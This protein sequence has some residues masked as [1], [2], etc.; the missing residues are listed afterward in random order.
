MFALFIDIQAV[1]KGGPL[2]NDLL[3]FSDK[4]CL[5]NFVFDK[6]MY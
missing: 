3:D 6:A 1:G 5:I 2:F 4:S